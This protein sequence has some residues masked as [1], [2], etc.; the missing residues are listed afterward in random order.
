MYR[1][2]ALIS[3]FVL[4]LAGC[5]VV[6]SPTLNLSSPAD[7]SPVISLSPTLTWGS[8]AG[9]AYRLM[10]STDSNFQDLVVDTSNL[11]DTTYQ[12]PSDKLQ[13]NTWYYWKVLAK[14][15]RTASNWTPA[16]SFQT[17]SHA[18]P[19]N[20]GTIRVE[21]TV[22]GKPWNGTL[23]YQISGP[24][25]DTDNSVPWEFTE[26][27]SGTYTITC[28]YGGPA[29]ATL[30][31][32][33][34]GPSQDLTGGGTIKF[35]LNYNTKAS[36]GV[37]INATLNGAPWSGDLRFT[38][39]GPTQ[40]AQS[41]VP[42]TKG[43]LPSGTYTLAY[44]TGGP[45][46]AVLTNIS[47]AAVQFLSEG[48]TVEYTLN[49]STG[50]ESHLSVSALFNGNGWSGPVQYSL[51]G[52]VSGSYSQVPLNLNDVPPGKY[53]ITYQAGGPQGA[54]LGNIAPAQS[55]N[56]GSGR[57]G[58][59][60]LNFF[61]GQQTGY[62]SIN[63]TLNGSP[64]SGVVNYSINGPVSFS[65]Q[66]VPR[67]HNNMPA[68]NYTIAYMGGGPSGA[69]LVGITPSYTQSLTGGGTIV[70]NLNFV[71][72]PKTGTITVNAV[73][74]GQP[75]KT[76]VG[77]GAISYSLAGPAP[78]SG[79]VIPGTFTGQPAGNYTLNYYSGGP[80]GATLTGI[81]PAP[82]MNLAPGGS[83]SFTL[84]FTG[85]PKGT[86]TVQAYLNGEPWSG[87]VSYVLQGPYV[88]SGGSAPRTFSNAPQG[89]YTV[90]YRAGGP[91]QSAFVGVSPSSQS[92]S[93]GGAI[94]FTI[95]FEFKGLPPQPPEPEPMP[96]PLLSPEPES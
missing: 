1:L 17:P 35:V 48:G 59:F 28:N 15:G 34:P 54:T 87:N 82:A 8:I 81:S 32:I 22:D 18:Q 61:T 50:Q 47:P 16:W 38:L 23:N 24:F 13:G 74:D 9:A 79:N 93:P 14:K 67:S 37:K 51:S 62:V 90:R 60:V 25:S 85:Q 63:A 7:R 4:L 71:E 26:V 11:H 36:S 68:G 41:I 65:D 72:Q 77:S 83:I 42:Q 91:P 55:I 20:I 40:Y 89:N 53:T 19:G 43:K 64:W 3:I 31:N 84:H 39:S 27:Q 78:D 70:F 73:L 33:T 56:L 30:T 66:Q 44:K 92:L 57:S 2:K 94:M 95:M 45:Q 10:V 52:P 69:T 46:G 86:V 5:A 88:E 76:M 12:I 75:W 49:F 96:G 6:P 58:G 80:I 21:A 29:G